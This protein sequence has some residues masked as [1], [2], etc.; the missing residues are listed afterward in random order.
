MPSRAI[1][2]CLTLVASAPACANEILGFRIGSTIEEAHFAARQ[3]KSELKDFNLG[4][5]REALT[6]FVS[7]S[8]PQIG[9]CRGRLVMVQMTMSGSLH[10][11]VHVFEKNRREF[12]EPRSTPFQTYAGSV[13]L[14]SLNLE[15]SKPDGVMATLSI[16]AFGTD[17]LTTSSGFFQPNPCWEDK[18]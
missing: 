4:G 7:P 8:G 16:G 13:Q 5:S 1:I 2:W 17:K 9:F 11:F 14:S 6:Y 15:W 3:I 18:R 10:E 12:G